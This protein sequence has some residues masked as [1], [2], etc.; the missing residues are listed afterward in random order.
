MHAN[1]STTLVQSFTNHIQKIEIAHYVNL[2]RNVK[3]GKN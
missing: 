1:N 2:K 3:I